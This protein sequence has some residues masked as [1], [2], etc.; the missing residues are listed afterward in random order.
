MLAT[1]T[2]ILKQRLNVEA[3]PLTFPQATKTDKTKQ[4]QPHHTSRKKKDRRLHLHCRL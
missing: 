1:H 2:R 3:S 4:E